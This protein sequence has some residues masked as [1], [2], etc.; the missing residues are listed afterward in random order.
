MN[1]YHTYQEFLEDLT[2]W[3][4]CIWNQ[5]PSFHPKE[6]FFTLLRKA[7]QRTEQEVFSPFLYLSLAAHLEWEDMMFLAAGFYTQQ[8]GESFTFA[9]LKRFWPREEADVP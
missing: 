9:V 1:L 7:V 8:K 3:G 4:D 5:Q 6:S 2:F